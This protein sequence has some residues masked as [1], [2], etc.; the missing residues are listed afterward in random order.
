MFCTVLLFAH[1]LVGKYAISSMA[2]CEAAL[3]EEAVPT[4]FVQMF[5]LDEDFSAFEENDLI[6]MP[7]D[8]DLIRCNEGNQ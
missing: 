2:I 1:C 6:S 5:P 8:K 4:L 3:H 7:I